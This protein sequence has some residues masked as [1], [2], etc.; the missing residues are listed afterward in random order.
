VSVPNQKIIRIE[1]DTYQSRFLQIGDEQWKK[2]FQT[3]KPTVFGMYLYLAS[4][5]DGY[6]LELSAAAVERE[7]GIKKTAYHTALKDLE[8]KGYLK[9]EQGNTYAFSP[10]PKFA[11]ANSASAN[12][13][14]ANLEVRICELPTPHLR[15]PDSAFA[16]LEV[17][18]RDIEIDNINKI[19]K[20][21]ITDIEKEKLEARFGKD[22]S[23]L[24]GEGWIDT[25]IPNFYDFAREKQIE[26]L[27]TTPI[28]DLTASQAEYVVDK[29]LN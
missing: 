29:I 19:N 17:R 6:L 24:K 4:N 1:K 28:F 12:S 25:Y 2:A 10:S 18:G 27:F 14:S 22:G 15:T 8:E 3:M 21:N 9:K 5:K 26:A 11:S 13:A 20:T 23:L 16:N 7:I